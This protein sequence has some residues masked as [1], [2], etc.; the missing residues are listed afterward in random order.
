M[1][2]IELYHRAAK[3][4]AEKELSYILNQHQILEKNPELK[5]KIT[6]RHNMTFYEAKTGEIRV[7]YHRQRTIDEEYLDA[8]LHKNKQY[9]WL[10]AEAY[11]E[12]EDFLEKIYAFHGKHD[13]NFWPLNDYGAAT[14][15]QLPNKDYEWY[16]NQATKKKGNPSKYIK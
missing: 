8:L 1:S 7:Y 14:L 3:S 4:T 6:S 9:Q 2:E 11:E 13:N 5:D 16:L 10:L 15:S 12:F